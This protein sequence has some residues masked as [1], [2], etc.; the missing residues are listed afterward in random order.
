MTPLYLF[1]DNTD[2]ALD[3]DHLL[4]RIHEEIHAEHLQTIVVSGETPAIF[5]ALKLYGRLHRVRIIQDLDPLDKQITAAENAPRLVIINKDK[6]GQEIID[7]RPAHLQTAVIYS[8]REETPNAPPRFLSLRK[9]N[10]RP[11]RR[12]SRKPQR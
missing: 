10:G 7:N 2:H 12:R 5:T 3:L 1:I 9:G 6:D 4:Q 8:R 11:S